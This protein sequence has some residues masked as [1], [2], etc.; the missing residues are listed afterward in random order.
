ML[1]SIAYQSNPDLLAKIIANFGGSDVL[2]KVEKTHLLSKLTL[3]ESKIPQTEER[4]ATTTNYLLKRKCLKL[5][6]KL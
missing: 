4:W 6:M 5:I 3:E 2:K 1:D